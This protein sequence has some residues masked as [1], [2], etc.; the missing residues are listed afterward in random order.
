MDQ[1][2]DLSWLNHMALVIAT[3][4]IFKSFE[5]SSRHKQNKLAIEPWQG[6]IMTDFDNND[7]VTKPYR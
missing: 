2:E 6:K 1:G 7:N 4:S 3:H 5:M